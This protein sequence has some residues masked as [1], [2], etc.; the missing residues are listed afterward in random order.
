MHS[1]DESGAT[2][3]VDLLYIPNS[4]VLA[5]RGAWWGKYNDLKQETAQQQQAAEAAA[6]QRDQHAIQ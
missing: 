3:E 4:Y 2:R 1:I 5:I 6:R